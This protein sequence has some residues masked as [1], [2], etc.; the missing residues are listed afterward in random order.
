MLRALWFAVK[1][2]LLVAASVWVANRP[3][4]IEAHWL[5]YD[6]RAHVGLALLLLLL[7]LVLT[8]FIYRILWGIVTMPKALRRYRQERSREKGFRAL[9]LGL[10]AVAAGDAK[11][12]EQQAERARRFLPSDRGL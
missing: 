7:V 11:Q 3:G 2:G 4:F 8:V 1:V 5:G 10:T 9:T 12:A 6:V